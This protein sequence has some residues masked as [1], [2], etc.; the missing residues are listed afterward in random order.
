MMMA[1]ALLL[2][3]TPL[4]GA[5]PLANDF[6]GTPRLS[7]YSRSQQQAEREV[8]QARALNP[9]AEAAALYAHAE[10]KYFLRD[11]AG[12]QTLADNALAIWS[13]EPPSASLAADLQQR[14]RKLYTL[15]NCAMAA[16]L[17]RLALTI[18][19][20]AEGGAGTQTVSVLGDLVPL[21]VRQRNKAAIAA[22]AARLADAWSRGG[23][24]AD[25]VSAPV[26]HALIDL[27]YDQQQYAAA[28]PLAQRAL[29]N[30][31][32]AYGKDEVR[33]APRL[34]D[35]ASL[36]YALM[37]TD[38]G[39]ATVA[40]ATRI[41]AK[42]PQ[43]PSE[44]SHQKDV[45]EQMR[46]LF[47]RGE[48]DAAIGLGE[49]ELAAMERTL[50]DDQRALSAAPPTPADPAIAARNRRRLEWHGSL[51][52]ALQVR[53]AELHHHRR[54]YVQAEP[55]YKHALA[56]Y[57]SMDGDQTLIAATRSD[58]AI[59]YRQTADYQRALTLQLQAFEFM[60]QAYGAAHPD[61]IDS[62]A[63]LAAIYTA[64][65]KT[66]EAALVAQKVPAILAPTKR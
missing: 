6:C 45:E 52:A 19:E 43:P 31:E 40:R 34:D 62:A 53:L 51:A 24:P 57:E 55:L 66:A 58:L 21:D 64:Q 61:V 46:K 26:Y 20:R 39:Q 15:D 16:P 30:A 22:N 41:R 10:L 4:A 60:L 14:A 7:S 32:L 37:R 27:H 48:V 18:S 29:R 9:L 47:K 54:S 8:E 23:E 36:Q 65:G 44:Y 56:R 50:L 42:P 1:A 11:R 33:V 17:L 28:E 13:A 38:D 2:A 63:E 3:A 49:R 35:L 5:A 59:L 12:A 25:A